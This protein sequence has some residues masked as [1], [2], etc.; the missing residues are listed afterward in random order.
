MAAVPV[1]E[2]KGRLELGFGQLDAMIWGACVR[3][4]RLDIFD[5]K[6]CDAGEFD[7][8]LLKICCLKLFYPFP[9]S[10]HKILDT[11]P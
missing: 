11:G 8:F 1:N 6:P 4:H 9:Y 5:R 3:C 10:G 7:F 2:G